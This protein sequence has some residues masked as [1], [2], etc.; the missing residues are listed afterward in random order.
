MARVRSRVIVPILK[1]L[2]TAAKRERKTFKSIATNNFFLVT[3]ILLQQAGVFLYLIGA[4]VVLFPLSADPLRKIPADRFPLWPLGKSERWKLRLLSP[5][6]N[7]VTWLLAALAAWSLKHTE[8][9]GVLLL[10]LT[11][12]G[13]GFLVPSA[14]G[15]PDFLRWIPAPRGALGQLIRKN[16]REILLTLDFYV[17][18]LLSVSG[19]IYRLAM[20]ALPS[21]ALMS[22]TLLITL[23][24]SSYAQCLFGLE[25]KSG[26]TR[27]QLMPLAGWKVIAAK[28]AAFLIVAVT[29]TLPL[30]PLTGLASALALLAFGHAPST[31]ERREQTRWRFSSGASLSSG[32]TQTIAL[33]GAGV[34]AF[35]ITPLIL[36]PCAIACAASAWWYGR[37]LY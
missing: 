8:S 33:A 16:V 17:A 20:R 24:L 31:E 5:W 11:L 12:F 34:T 37:K 15:E 7:P 19:L 28:D 35:R 4:L 25:S 29:L 32:I 21:E 9:L 13:V 2:A 18:L 3:A 14:G 36:I 23:A 6:I 1:A 30:A 10:A 27:Y 22:I 26:L